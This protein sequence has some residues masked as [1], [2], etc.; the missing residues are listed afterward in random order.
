MLFSN[1]LSPID[2]ADVHMNCIKIDYVSSIRFL[3]VII[4]DKLRFN[5][6]IKE[7][8]RKISKNTG[9]LYKLKQYVPISTLLSV[10]R[11][12]IECYINYCNLI[13]GNA[14][15]THL[16]PLI[17]AQKKAVRIIANLH[18]LSHTHHI[19]SNLKIL[20]VSDHYKYNLGIFMW[21]N[22]DYFMPNYR[23][24]LN[25][26]RS[27]NYFDSSYHRLSLTQ[28]QSISYQA[29]SNWRKIPESVKNATSLNTFKKRYKNSL[30]SSYDNNR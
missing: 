12:I 19:F 5:Y 13:F 2:I 29:P 28:N 21:K 11:S 1:I 17:I 16:S 26:T 24:N 7:I 4:D 9:V 18:P 23:I 22:F 30:L 10:Y 14:S 6:H 25:N 8:T 15:D 3:G 27:G 20:K